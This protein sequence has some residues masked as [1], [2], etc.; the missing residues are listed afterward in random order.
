[1][2]LSFAFGAIGSLRSRQGV[3]FGTHHGVV[4]FRFWFIDAQKK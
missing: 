4:V 3:L 1:M 2:N